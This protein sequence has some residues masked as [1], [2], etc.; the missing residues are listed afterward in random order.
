MFYWLSQAAAAST[1]SSGITVALGTATETDTAQTLAVVKALGITQ[2]A[3][4]DTA[5]VIS[6]STAIVVPVGVAVETD[7][8]QAVSAGKLRSIAQ[9]TETDA[10]SVLG[11]S[12]VKLVSQALEADTALTI[13]PNT[14]ISVPLGAATETDGAGSFARGKRRGLPV[15]AEI[16]SSGAITVRKVVALGVSLET[17]TAASLAPGKAR[18]LGQASEQ[19]LAVAFGIV[20]GATPSGGVQLSMTLAFSDTTE[21]S[22]PFSIAV[23]QGGGLTGLTVQAAVRD[24]GSTTSYLDFADL[25]FKTSG[26]GQKEISLSEVGQGVYQGSVNIAGITNLPVTDLVVEY[27][28]S[29]RVSETGISPIIFLQRKIANAVHTDARALTVPKFIG[30]KDV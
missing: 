9:A 23:S 16:S 17:D 1:L 2:A 3:E 19:N 25:T 5:L 4:T 6:P 28:V 11:S 21:T 18:I 29:G 15:A 7:T 14:V 26:W 30:L 13:S 20:G 8:A 24:A 22:L 12:K 27:Y 10:A